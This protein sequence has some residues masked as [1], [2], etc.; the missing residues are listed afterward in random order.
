[1]MSSL[2]IVAVVLAVMLALTG[3]M[4]VLAYS[5]QQLLTRRLAATND[6]LAAVEL[7]LLNSTF[8]LDHA[9]RA[10]AQ[11]NASLARAQT[12]IA[13]LNVS[14]AQANA[15]LA[16]DQALL[17]LSNRTTIVSD[18]FVQE[19]ATDVSPAVATFTAAY[20]GYVVVSGYTSATQ[21]YVYADTVEANG[22]TAQATNLVPLT[23]TGQFGVRI[24]V[25]PGTV[26]VYFSSSDTAYDSATV[27]VTYVF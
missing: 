21:G 17:S 2:R 18:Q 4:A 12:T 20:A 16:R 23:F 8:A 25:L 3:G 9:T 13:Y 27:T 5:N 24:P 1:M 10:L 11:A 7:S 15:S 6:R 19:T 14:L 26:T 22:Q